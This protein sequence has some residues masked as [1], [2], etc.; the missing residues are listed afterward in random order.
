MTTTELRA[1]I[2]K[3]LNALPFQGPAG[4]WGVIL[5]AFTCPTEFIAAPSRMGSGGMGLSWVVWS[6][7]IPLLIRIMDDITELHRQGE[8]PFSKIQFGRAEP[9]DVDGSDVVGFRYDYFQDSGMPKEGYDF[10]GGRDFI[11]GYLGALEQGPS[12]GLDKVLAEK[13]AD[14]EELEKWLGLRDW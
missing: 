4:F 14:G 8:T 9:L 6:D 10:C 13:V 5:E 7:N 2:F 3:R 12:E 11:E 1:D